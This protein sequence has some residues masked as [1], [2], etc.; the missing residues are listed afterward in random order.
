MSAPAII[1]PE[2]LPSLI[3]KA[4]NALLSARDSAEV[5]E[6]RDMARVAYDAAKSAGRIARAQAAHDEVLARVHEA[7][8]DAIRIRSLA[9]I[10]LADVYDAAQERGEVRR[11]GERGKAVVDNNSFSPATAADLGIRRDEIQEARKLR[12]AERESPGLIDRALDAM[13]RPPAPENG[14]APAPRE[15]TRAELM[16]EIEAERAARAA[17]KREARDQ[18]ERELAARIREGSKA[19]DRAS[20]EYG[21]ILADPPWR[22]E[23]YS[24]ET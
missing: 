9:E 11:D 8:A 4:A 17:A 20:K 24:R 2:A 21:V 6:A 12:D 15:P 1:S 14:P 3:D 5:L 19:L 10:R 7:Q 16:R 22:F 18:R 13:I 23:P